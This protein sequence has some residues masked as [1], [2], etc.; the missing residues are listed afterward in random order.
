MV[1]IKSDTELIKEYTSVLEEMFDMI[2]DLEEFL[3]YH[4][5]NDFEKIKAAWQD[6]ED[7]KITRKQ[8]IG[9]GIKIL[10]KQFI[11][12]LLGKINPF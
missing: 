6:Y 4:L 1:H 7:G 11:K 9:H 8:L 12:K 10:G 3:K 5:A 2:D